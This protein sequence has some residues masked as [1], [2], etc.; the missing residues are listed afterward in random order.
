MKTKSIIPAI[1]ILSMGGAC[2]S[3]D[4]KSYTKDNVVI[5]S[6]KA[7]TVKNT[8]TSKELYKIADF[9]YELEKKQLDK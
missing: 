1:L 8:A 4:N 2:S 3:S 5:V 7:N 9:Y 6:V